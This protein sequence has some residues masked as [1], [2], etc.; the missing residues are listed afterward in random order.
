MCLATHAGYAKYKGLPG[1]IR[2]GCPNTPA[3]KLRFCSVHK[4]TLPTPGN[5]EHLSSASPPSSRQQRQPEMVIG[6]RSTRQGTL[7]EV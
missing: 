1:A 4:P 5:D 7:Y 3:L 6:K 2:T